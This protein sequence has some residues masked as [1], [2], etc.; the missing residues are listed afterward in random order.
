MALAAGRTLKIRDVSQGKGAAGFRKVLCSGYYG[1]D[2]NVVFW[3]EFLPASSG[4]EVAPKLILV[5]GRI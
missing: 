5:L 3:A 2:I 1:A 4:E